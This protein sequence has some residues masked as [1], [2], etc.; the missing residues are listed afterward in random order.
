[1]GALRN[2]G[3]I[4][5]SILFVL[6]FSIALILYPTKNMLTFDS[7]KNFT[8]PLISSQLNLTQEQK[9]L[10]ASY[11]STS[12][13]NKDYITIEFPENLTIDCSKARNLNEN[14]VENFLI[15]TYLSQIYFK[16]YNCDA[17]QCLKEKKMMYFLSFDFYQLL[18]KLFTYSLIAC[19]FTGIAYFLLLENWKERT[20]GFASTFL[21][22]GIPYLFFDKIFSFFEEKIP[23]EVI[24]LIKENFSFLEYF[25][26]I[27]L[28]L[29][30]IYIFLAIKDLYSK[31][32][33]K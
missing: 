29:L 30:A 22:V 33:R 19:I 20:L 10:L 9:N 31:K 21:L 32:K 8:A 27:G 18:Q 24:A 4:V 16:K 25:I 2:F 14:N 23:A 26:F 11:L 5:F 17:L 3:K 12:C 28:I 15:D 6:S 7:L 13:Q 1:M